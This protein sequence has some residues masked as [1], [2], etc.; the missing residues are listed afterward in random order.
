MDT[1][2]ST[3][4]APA[5]AGSALML[6]AALTLTACQQADEGAGGEESEETATASASPSGSGEAPSS[7]SG[8][9]EPGDA[10]T[11]ASSLPD[12]LQAPD[13][14][15][16]QAMMKAAE[17]GMG[18]AVADVQGKDVAAHERDAKNTLDIFED[19]PGVAPIDSEQCRAVVQKMYEADAGLAARST[20]LRG[21]ESAEGRTAESSDGTA[22]SMPAIVSLPYTVT[23]TTYEDAASAQEH[24]DALLAVQQEEECRGESMLGFGAA[25]DVTE[26]EW[27][28]GTRY[29]GVSENEGQGMVHVTTV[30]VDGSRIIEILDSGIPGET[31]PD[32]S[33]EAHAKTADLLA[34]AL[35]EPHRD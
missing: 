10:E 28:E 18:R 25:G 4:T 14:D 13:N 26:Q 24:M 23:V 9:G 3:S 32:E 7:G 2:K 16:T 11:S 22:P 27:G 30:A 34:D 21:E 1:T 12:H 20:T 35:G 6:A 31:D 33:I 15:A 29:T 19:N 17:K 8:D 5:L